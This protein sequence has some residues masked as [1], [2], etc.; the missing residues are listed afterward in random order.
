MAD[1][2]RLEYLMEQ[3]CANRCSATERQELLRLIHEGR[4]TEAIKSLMGASWP[5]LSADYQLGDAPSEAILAAI[6]GTETAIVLPM[7]PGQRRNNRSR[8]GRAAAAAILVI[9]AGAGSYL[10]LSKRPQPIIANSNIRHDA[11]PGRNAAILTIAGG[12]QITLD[13]TARGLIGRQGNTTITNTD[14][15]LLYTSLSERPAEIQVNTLTTRRGNQ[16]QLVLPDGSKVWLNAAS[17]ITY[18]TAFAGNDRTVAI[19]GEAYFEVLHKNKMPFRV[20]AGNQVIEDLGTHFDINAY[21][22]EPV[23][24]TTLLEGAIKI[25]GLI[26]KPGEQAG[27]GSNGKMT[28]LKDVDLDGIVAW[29]DG[30]FR[31]N[32]VDIE[33]IMRQAARWYDLDVEYDGKIDETFSGGISRNVNASELLHILEIT[34]KVH[35]DIEGKKI[36]V[37]PVPKD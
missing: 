5:R 4:H 33:S 37:K 28:V 19:T 29:K 10:Y 26:L 22:D 8:W 14:G 18:P 1:Q 6:F 3:Y 30:K 16:Y 35:F 2:P 36:I 7:E 11:D 21:T 23:F 32:S 24:K 15:R 13:S 20:K 25:N 34:K 9:A 17:S 31:Y 12:K 27:I